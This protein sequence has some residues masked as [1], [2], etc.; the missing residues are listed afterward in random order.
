MIILDKNHMIDS[1]GSQYILLSDTG[2]ID[3]KTGEKAYNTIGYFSKLKTAVMAYCEIKQM[4]CVHDNDLSLKEA[5]HEMGAIYDRIMS[6]DLKED[7]S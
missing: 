7:N 5:V 4:E 3:K 6:L 1:D 2:R